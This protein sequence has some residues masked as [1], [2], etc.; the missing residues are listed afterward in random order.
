MNDTDVIA[1]IYPYNDQNEQIGKA[2][3]TSSYY[4]APLLPNAQPQ[5]TDTHGER[6]STEPPDFVDVPIHHYLPCVELRLSHIPRCRQGIIFGRGLDSDVIL[7][8]Y[9]GIGS[10]HFSITFDRENRL[11]LKDWGS[12][13][14]CEV[15][16]QGE[17][18]GIR[19]NF[20]WIVGGAELPLKRKSIYVNIYS[21]PPIHLDIIVNQQDWASVEYINSVRCFRQ[22]LATAEDQLVNLNIPNHKETEWPSGANTPGKGA[23]YLTT[24][25]G[26]GSFSTVT[27]YWNVS[28]AAQYALKEPSVKAIRDRR[29][30]IADWQREI[31][32]MSQ[33]SHVRILH[34][35]LLDSC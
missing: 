27:H 24:K 2:F 25:I 3:K 4:V 12:R 13:I 1:R 17:G 22:G 10:Y 26:E 35:Y 30:N 23:I 11:I 7:Q 31:R 18:R 20:C 21:V 19:R 33:I 32:I 8:H 14:G 15:L 34:S 9:K 5:L 6:E 29:V 16:Y 28:T